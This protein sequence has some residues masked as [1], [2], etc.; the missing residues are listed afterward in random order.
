MALRSRDFQEAIDELVSISLKT[1]AISII[2]SFVDVSSDHL[3]GK[4]NKDK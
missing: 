2:L 4:E 1:L 3:Q